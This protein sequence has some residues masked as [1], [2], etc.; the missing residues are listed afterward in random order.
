MTDPAVLIRPQPCALRAGT[1]PVT[2]RAAFADEW[3]V[4]LSSPGFT[5]GVVPGMLGREDAEQVVLALAR[6]E[7]TSQD[8]EHAAKEAVTAAA[9]VAWWKAAKLVGW[10]TGGA[11]EWWGRLVLRGVDPERLTFA[12]W[13]A[14][15]FALVCEGLDAQ[16]REK[17]LFTFDMPPA[18]VMDF[19]AWS[20]DP[21]SSAG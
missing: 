16:G 19:S 12:A 10:A 1:V 6:G 3:I 5:T 15:V 20:M 14:A 7:I 13:C 21:P 11:G 17:L 2:V 8:L 9:G 4:L 18:G